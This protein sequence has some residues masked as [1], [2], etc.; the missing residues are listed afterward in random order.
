[1]TNNTNNLKP[2]STQRL[3]AWNGL[4]FLTPKNWELSETELSKGINRIVLEDD[5]MPRLELDWITPKDALDKDKVQKQC[6]KQTRKLSEAACEVVEVKGISNE[7]TAHEYRMPDS[8]TLLI[9][10]RVPSDTT[11]PFAFFRLHFSPKTSE[12]PAVCFR[13]IAKSFSWYN[14]G[15]TPWSFYDVDFRLNRD[16]RLVATS[17]QAGRK[18]LSFEWRLRRLFLWYFSLAD[19]VLREKSLAQ[20]CADFLNNLKLLPVPLWI[21]QGDTALSYKRHKLY[22]L[23]QFEEIGRMCFKYHAEARLFPDKNQIA[24]WVI[25]YRKESDLEKLSEEL[26]IDAQQPNHNNQLQ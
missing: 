6:Q 23:G 1:M 26:A 15:L 5:A 9:A 13:S 20:Y 14:A 10:Y 17:L 4:A 24:L 19:I 22:F 2:D 16:F 21:P 25:Q 3:F 18:T 7:W 11:S 12:S 8:R